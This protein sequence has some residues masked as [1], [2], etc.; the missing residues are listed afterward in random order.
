MPSEGGEWASAVVLGLMSFAVT[1]TVTALHLLGYWG[2]GPVLAM[3]LMYGGAV[4]FIAGIIELKRGEM[5]AGTTFVSFGTFWL[6]FVAHNW[7]LPMMG[8]ESGNMETFGFFLGWALFTIAP[9]AASWKH[10]KLLFIVFVMVELA[11]IQLALLALGIGSVKAAA[12]QVLAVALMAW[13]LGLA[14][15]V[16]REYGRTVLPVF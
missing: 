5:F 6:T 3:A 2:A 7:L 14:T 10:G 15:M 8:V 4:Q 1:T 9:L 13:Y 11:F 16:N 12:L